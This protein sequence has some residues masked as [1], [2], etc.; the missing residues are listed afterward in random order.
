MS[1]GPPFDD[2]DSSDRLRLGLSIG[3]AA[4]LLFFAG[5]AILASERSLGDSLTIH[6]DVT[7][8]GTLNT[9]AVLRLAG[10]PIGEVVAIR[11][12]RAPPSPHAS[13]A[14][15]AAEP[16]AEPMID[17]ELRLLRKY[18]ERVRRN[19]TVV[20][21]NPTLLTEAQLEVGPAAA[22]GARRGGAGGDHLRGVDPADMSVLCCASIAALGDALRETKE[23]SPDWTEFTG[24]MSTL[25]GHVSETLPTTELLRLAVHA[26]GLDAWSSRC[27]TS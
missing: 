1:L 2:A 14:T 15:P 26:E 20:T 17:I 24:A 10:E 11:G 4:L 23:L 19:S 16:Q 21:V 18:R 25:S 3:A 5:F 7:R 13:P 9:G 22:G 8:I 6:V 27:A 12:R